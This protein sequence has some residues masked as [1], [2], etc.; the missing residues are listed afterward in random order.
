MKTFILLIA[1][2]TFYAGEAQTLIEKTWPVKAGQ[3]IRLKFDYPENIRISTWDKKEISIQ[4]TVAINGGKDDSIFVLR[5][6]ID[7]GSITISN[8]PLRFKGRSGKNITIGGKTI[9][10]SDNHIDI[11]MEIKVPDGTATH[12]ESL[13]GLVEVRH[14]NG[15]A[16]IKATYGGIDASLSKKETGNLAVSVNY[17]Q[18]YSD[19]DLTYTDQVNKDFHTAFKATYGTGSQLGLESGYGNIYLRKAL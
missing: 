14:F 12:L 15:P 13:Y 11:A 6:V 2:T 7:E 10:T 4:A 8:K 3:E 16:E 17:G 9:T 1:L 5:E 18:I 19:L